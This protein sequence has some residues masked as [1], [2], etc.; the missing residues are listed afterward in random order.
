MLRLAG[1]LAQFW[2]L[3]GHSAEG[4]DWMEAALTLSGADAT[5]AAIRSP[6]PR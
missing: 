1:A 6:A 5:P 3:R 2:T 4:R